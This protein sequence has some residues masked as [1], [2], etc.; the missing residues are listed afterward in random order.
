M[1]GETNEGLGP[2]GKKNGGPLKGEKTVGEILLEK[3]KKAKLTRLQVS[4]ATRVPEDA[5]KYLETDN[6]EMLPA[7]VYVRGF[8]KSYAGYLGLDV[9]YIL[10][11]Y[12]VQTGQTHISKGDYWEVEEDVEEDE[13]RSFGLK[14][15]V[16]TIAAVALFIVII[17]LIVKSGGDDVDVR[18]PKAIPEASEIIKQDEM[19]EAGLA[20]ED[21]QGAVSEDEVAEETPAEI[22]EDEAPVEESIDLG[23]QME[24]KL[25]ANRSDSTW[26]SLMTISRIRNRPDTSYYDFILFPES[27]KTFRATD[28]FI[29]R[30]IGNAGGF[31]IEFMGE[32]LPPL[33]ETD[34][35]LRNVVIDREGIKRR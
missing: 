35:V 23:E 19:K 24:I 31:S 1:T 18:P 29:F 3:R 34:E 21:A 15:G 10:S 16:I 20:Q 7:R 2:I 30:T 13:G 12:E 17:T 5:L 26:I 22:I 11:K 28:A 8:L 32:R 27:R 14:S 9:D 33:G 25:I 4:E 6:F